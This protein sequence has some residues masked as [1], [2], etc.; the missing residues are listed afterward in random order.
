MSLRRILIVADQIFEIETYNGKTNLGLLT[1]KAS[2]NVVDID[3][4]CEE[5]IALAPHILHDTRTFGRQSKP[6]SHYLYQVEDDLPATIKFQNGQMLLELRSDGCQTLY[7]GSTNP[8]NEVVRWDDDRDICKISASE[9]QESVKKLAAMTL[10]ARLWKEHSRHNIALPLSGWLLRNGRDESEVAYFI[11]VI[12]EA[13]GDDQIKDRMKCVET[14][15]ERLKNGETVKGFPE[16][17]K[18]IGKDVAEKIAEWLGMKSERFFDVRTL[19][20][21]ERCTDRGNAEGFITFA[22]GDLRY[23]SE[24][25]TWSMW[26]KSHWEIGESA[27]VFVKTLAIDYAKSIFDEAKNSTDN[28]ERLGRHAAYSNSAKGI[29]NFI[30]LASSV[31]DVPVSIEQ[32]DTDPDLLNVLNGTIDLRTGELRPH[33]RDEYHS[34]LAPVFYDPNAKC[35]RW[36]RFLLEIFRGD[37]ELVKYMQRVIGYSLTGR[38]REEKFFLLYGDGRNGKGTMVETLQAILGDY[39]DTVSPELLL[40]T[41]NKD[42]RTANPELAKLKGIRFAPASETDAKR[43]LA[44]ALVKNITGGDSITTRDV[45]QSSF[46]Y[47]PQFKLWLATNKKPVVTG[48]DTG[49]WERIKMIP[50][51]A[52]FKGAQG[53]TTLKE[54]LKS[55]APGILA[56]CV[57]G[58][59]AWYRDE[60]GTCK[61]VEDATLNYREENDTVSQ[62]INECCETGDETSHSVSSGLLYKT[63]EKYC[64][65]ENISAVDSKDFK[66]SLSSREITWKRTKRGIFFQGI[67]LTSTPDPFTEMKKASLSVRA[68]LDWEAGAVE[69]G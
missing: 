42:A 64:E 15:A 40:Q 45:F 63:Y 51:L 62:F 16:L 31:R 65:D 48:T 35:E 53:D 54:T 58:S 11:T 29:S 52:S 43:K 26:D 17:A 57:R 5:A 59:V 28:R 49:M 60:L 12:A 25:K 18:L 10:L 46:T 22:D 8:S 44:E 14:T 23:V 61:A 13:A 67:A 33:S 21:A 32:F 7:P 41:K 1:G 38:T 4:D 47:R 68:E 24:K 27:T 2:E 3:L 39:A 69:I 6:R 56:W 66:T 55:E 34:K 36:E 20:I 19:P 9:L 37:Q 30:T 50:F